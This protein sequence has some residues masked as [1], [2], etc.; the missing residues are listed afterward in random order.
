[1]RREWVY[2]DVET[3]EAEFMALPNKDEAK[4]LSLME[5]YRT[6][7]FG[8]PSP[9]MVDDYGDGLYRLRHIKV[10]YKGRLIFFS[11]D[12]AGNYDRLV[13]F[14]V[15]KKESQDVPQNVMDRARRRMKEYRLRK[16][17]NG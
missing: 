17:E 5:H 16:N 4:L 10:A 3:I 8:N 14:T 13:V 2:F 9:A 1:M 7:G 12:R 15:Y 6:V 11:I